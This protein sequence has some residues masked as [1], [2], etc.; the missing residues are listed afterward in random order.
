MSRRSFFFLVQIFGDH[1]KLAKWFNNEPKPKLEYCLFRDVS[2]KESIY[3][4][5]PF[6]FV[7]YMFERAAGKN[8]YSKRHFDYLH[9]RHF[10][11]LLFPSFWLISFSAILF[12]YIFRHFVHLL[13]PPFCSFTLS[14]ILFIYLFRHFVHLLFPPLCSFNFSTILIILIYLSLFIEW[15][16]GFVDVFKLYSVDC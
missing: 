5:F 13:F 16:F 1:F 6:I 15:H 7:M 14:A 11:Y 8:R 3:F 10:P 12:I 9:L 2:T 4:F